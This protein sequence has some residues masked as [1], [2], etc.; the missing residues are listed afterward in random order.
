MRIGFEHASKYNTVL[1]EIWP[2]IVRG[3]MKDQFDTHGTQMMFAL[4]EKPYRR[5]Y[6]RLVRWLSDLRRK[7]S[8]M[9]TI[10]YEQEKQMCAREVLWVQR[11]MY[12]SFR[13]LKKY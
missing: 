13:V 12:S 4:N 3:G 9:W 5:A 6:T 1:N 7:N 10:V 2:K 8:K 11:I